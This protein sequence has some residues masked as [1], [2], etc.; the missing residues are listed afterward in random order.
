MILKREATASWA[1]DTGACS[2]G[3]GDPVVSSSWGGSSQGVSYEVISSPGQVFSTTI[4]P[5]ADS[6]QYGVA[7]SGHIGG[8][9]GVS[10]KATAYCVR[11]VREGLTDVNGNSEILIGQKFNWSLRL[12]G[13]NDHD[14]VDGTWSLTGNSK[15]FKSYVVSA[16][17]AQ[18]NAFLPVTSFSLQ[19]IAA[20]F[21]SPGFANAHVALKLEFTGNSEPALQFSVSNSHEVKAPAVSAG[22]HSMGTMKLTTSGYVPQVTDPSWFALHGATYP[23]KPIWGIYFPATVTTPT[24]YTSAGSGQYFFVNMMSTKSTIYQPPSGPIIPIPQGGPFVGS[25]DGAYP[26]PGTEAAANGALISLFT[27]RPRISAD[28]PADLISISPI[29]AENDFELYVM[30]RPPNS[31]AGPSMDVPL[32]RNT[33]K[34]KGDAQYINGSWT[35]TDTGSF[36]LSKSLLFPPHPVWNHVVGIGP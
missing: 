21:A 5:S 7:P 3:L 1:G 36:F 26:Y 28:T 6:Q 35:G 20:Y 22:P 11:M 23:A 12:D 19:S 2:N 27:D 34:N 32:R 14:S 25:L 24:P 31:S 4:S 17:S 9:A 30:Y 8:S 16:S 13:F 15:P 33:W 10:F 18:F 29:H